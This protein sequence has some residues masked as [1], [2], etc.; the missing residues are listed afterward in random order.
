M[1]CRNTIFG[2]I[3]TICFCLKLLVLKSGKLSFKSNIRM[4]AE[5][6]HSYTDSPAPASIKKPWRFLTYG[7][8][9]GYYRKSEDNVIVAERRLA[10]FNFLPKKRGNTKKVVIFLYKVGFNLAISCDEHEVDTR[11]C[12]IKSLNNIFFNNK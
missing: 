1:A 8:L 5:G 10:S 4:H 6:K 9:T 12:I 7:C 11:K 2:L 3:L